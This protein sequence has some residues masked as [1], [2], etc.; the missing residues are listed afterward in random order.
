MSGTN[1]SFDHPGGSERH[2]PVFLAL[3]TGLV[4]GLGLI[5]WVQA[6]GDDRSAA[7]A[8]GAMQL[9][10]TWSCLRLLRLD[11]LSPV[12]IYLYL[13]GVFHLGLVVPWALGVHQRPLPYWMEVNRLSPAL[14][15]VILA[16]AAYQVGAGLAVW[17]WPARRTNASGGPTRYSNAV[18]YHCGLG[19]V[20]LGLLVFCWGLRTLGLE[21]LLQL[22]YFETYALTRRFDPRFFITSLT[23][24]PIG[25][26]LAAAAAPWR[27]IPVVVAVGSVWGACIL[28]LGFRGYALVPAVAVLAVL[29]KRG[30]RPSK[31]I[32][33]LGAAA[34]LTV[35]PIVR[36]MRDSRLAERSFAQALEAAGPAAA[37]EEMGGSLR[38]LVHTLRFMETEPLRWGRTYWQALKATVPNL[39]LAW[40]GGTYVS[41]EDLPPN[42]WVTRQ[43]APQLY[44]HFGGLGFS[45][46]AEPYMNFGASGVALCFLALGAGLVW[47]YRFDAARPTRLA[48]WAV[49]LGPLLWT[50]RNDFHAFFRPAI[51]G[52]VSVYA[53]RVIAD[54]LTAVRGEPVAHRRPRKRGDSHSNISPQPKLIDEVA[55]P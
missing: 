8:A 52:I 34:L 45:A 18:L 21:R 37:I 2:P 4:S 35:I 23:L 31:A 19:I 32:C 13:F 54:S 1:T 29:S 43:A 5:L 55:A 49:V 53:A 12:M 3:G 14:T 42:H 39:S 33:V 28:F 20:V 36:A 50:T 15:L 30:A 25:L 44:R 22:N 41:L 40:Q 16:L 11:A 26:Y 27:R 47:A 9:V 10:C 24:V 38:P 48:L 6:A 46:V 7:L 17:R 51:L